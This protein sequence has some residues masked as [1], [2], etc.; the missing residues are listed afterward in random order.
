VKCDGETNPQEVRDAGQC[1]TEIGLA[2]VRPSEFIIFRI[3]QRTKDIIM[4]EPIS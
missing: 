2:A 4:E 3:G 1:I